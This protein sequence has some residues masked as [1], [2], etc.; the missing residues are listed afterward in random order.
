MAHDGG[1]LP[2]QVPATINIRILDP[3]DKP[4]AFSSPLYQFSVM[5]NVVV[6]SRMGT[7][8]ATNSNPGKH[9]HHDIKK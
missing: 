5:E 4:P 6:G 9:N 1:N 3:S 7:V 8:S 2:A